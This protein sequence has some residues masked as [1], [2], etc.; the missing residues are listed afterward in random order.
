VTQIGY[1]CDFQISMSVKTYGIVFSNYLGFFIWYRLYVWGSNLFV[2]TME[3]LFSRCNPVYSVFFSSQHLVQFIVPFVEVISFEVK[4][5]I[6]VFDTKFVS[7]KKFWE[8]WFWGSRTPYSRL[9]T[10]PDTLTA[11]AGTETVCN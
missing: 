8:C 4:F 1:I 5:E 3:S 11:V 7:R 2:K 6:S 10:F 9:M